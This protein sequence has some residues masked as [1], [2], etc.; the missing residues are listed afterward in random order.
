MRVYVPHFSGWALR[1][2]PSQ[3]PRGTVADEQPPFAR[4]AFLHA[5]YPPPN[6]EKAIWEGGYESVKWSTDAKLVNALPTP[7]ITGSAADPVSDKWLIP[8]GLNDYSWVYTSDPDELTWQDDGTIT[9]TEGNAP[10][11]C[12]GTPYGPGTIVCANTDNGGYRAIFATSYTNDCKVDNATFI[13]AKYVRAERACTCVSVCV[14]A[15]ACTRAC[16]HTA[17]WQDARTDAHTRTGLGRSAAR[18]K[19]ATRPSPTPSFTARPR[20]VPTVT[21]DQ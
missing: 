5:A 21:T 16:I 2:R 8:T 15:R 17:A 1:Q 10:S 9:W 14:R 6:C 11:I 13:Y 20:T 12:T 7:Y 19:L 18:P 4:P 3:P